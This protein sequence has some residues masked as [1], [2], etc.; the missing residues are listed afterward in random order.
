MKHDHFTF[1]Y[2]Q[3]IACVD[4]G[5]CHVY[6]HFIYIETTNFIY[7]RTFLHLY[8]KKYIRLK[9]PFLLVSELTAHQSITYRSTPS[10]HSSL[11]NSPVVIC[12]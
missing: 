7:I 8:Y 2:D 12:S 5:I 1:K 10:F 3:I 6:Y 11:H 9:Y 4:I